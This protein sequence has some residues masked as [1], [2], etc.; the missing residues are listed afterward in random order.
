LRRIEN[1]HPSYKKYQNGKN[2][3]MKI[4]IIILFFII[5]FLLSTTIQLDIKKIAIFNKKIKFNIYI[6]IYICNKI[7]LYKRKVRKKDILKLI[8]IS[9]KRKIL[10]EEKIIFKS[11]SLDIKNI[12]IEI[13]YN[14]KNQIYMAYIY[15]ILQGI[16]NIGV[17]FAKTN[18]REIIIKNKSKDYT[19]LYIST[20]IN[21]NIIKTILRSI[22]NLSN[23][24]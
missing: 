14:V 22:K 16:T 23:T 7:L 8:Q 20:K 2:S 9:K 11:L 18:K 10:K 15:G 3:I 1:K 12:N 6:K 19:Y 5:F 24:R 21:I 17:S 13:G 4:F